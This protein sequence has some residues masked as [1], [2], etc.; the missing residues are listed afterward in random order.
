M[1]VDITEFLMMLDKES[2]KAQQ[3]GRNR[4]YLKGIR[5]A[6]KIAK[7]W[8]NEQNAEPETV[9]VN[10]GGV[11]S[12]NIWWYECS[13]CNNGVNSDWKFCTKCGSK[14]DWDNSFSDFERGIVEKFAKFSKA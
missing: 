13:K 12:S 9:K 6:G 10:I 5:D 7:Y 14:L 2:D 11:A 4:A 8:A 1:K 3:E